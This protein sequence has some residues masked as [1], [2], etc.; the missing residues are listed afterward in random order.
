MIWWMRCFSVIVLILFAGCKFEM[1]QE[2]ISQI[3]QGKE[4]VSLGSVR[5]RNH[6]I[7]LEHGEMFSVL[8]S[9]GQVLAYRL[10]TDEFQQ[11]FPE[12]YD[13]I[14]SAVADMIFANPCLFD[15]GL[16]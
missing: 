15:A 3:E 8:T 14:N 9:D 13:E 12:L 11:K 10:K 1:S 4:T 16:H 6:I 7:R 5:M 2:S